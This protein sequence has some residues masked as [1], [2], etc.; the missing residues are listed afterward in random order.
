[1]IYPKGRVEQDG[2]APTKVRAP[3]HG[4]TSMFSKTL[5]ALL[6]ALVLTT[7]Y[8]SAQAQSRCVSANT[9]ESTLSAYPAWQV[10]QR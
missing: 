2:P 10:C 1:M 3:T 7:S 9:E 6:A 8:V 4:D 5:F